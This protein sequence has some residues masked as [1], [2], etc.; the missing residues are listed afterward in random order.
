MITGFVVTLLLLFFVPFLRS[1]TSLYLESKD[2]TYI[3]CESE[4]CIPQTYDYNN[5]YLKHTLYHE[6][7]FDVSNIR[8]DTIYTL[9]YS[10]IGNGIGFINTSDGAIE[11]NGIQLLVTFGMTLVYGIIGFYAF[12][13]RKLE[14]SETS[15]ANMNVHLFVKFLTMFPICLLAYIVIKNASIY[16]ILF[17]F[18]L[19]LVYYFVYD[20]IT[21]KTID[22]IK[23]SIISFILSVMIIWVYGYILDVSNEN[24]KTIILKEK[25]IT[26]IEVSGNYF[27]FLNTNY[28][29]VTDSDTIAYLLSLLT[30]PQDGDSYYLASLKM[31]VNGNI[32]EANLLSHEEDNTA[33]F[34]KLNRVSSVENTNILNSVY[35]I[36]TNDQLANKTQKKDILNDIKQNIDNKISQTCPIASHIT[37]YEYKNHQVV[38]TIVSTC[39]SSSLQEKVALLANKKV[40]EKIDNLVYLTYEDAPLDFPYFVDNDTYEIYQF[41]LNH[42]DDPIDID[43]DILIL[44]TSYG[45]GYTPFYT[46]AKEEFETLVSSLREKAKDTDEYQQY[47]ASLDGETDEY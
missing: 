35:A 3:Q 21:K 18:V 24:S 22:H 8:Y 32:Y 10:I 38:T 34:E 28:Y 15:F 27:D 25:E 37:L 29:E 40:A 1:Y 31:Y 7:Y 4:A 2:E 41:I 33:F 36:E 42:L 5:A 14:V 11:Y 6:Y 26:K 47:M 30:E 46:N 39:L 16:L 43:K 19:L 44:Y 12:S 13:K 9:P 45:N 20:L 17:I 23:K